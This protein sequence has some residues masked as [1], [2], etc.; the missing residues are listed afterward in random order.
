[1]GSEFDKSAPTT[2]FCYDYYVKTG[3]NPN[4]GAAGT[5]IGP[6]DISNWKVDTV[7]GKDFKAGDKIATRFTLYFDKDGQ[8]ISVTAI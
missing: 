6:G 7:I 1:M 5:G 4:R 8:L 2:G 3:L